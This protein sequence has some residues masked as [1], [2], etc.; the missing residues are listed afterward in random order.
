MRLLSW[1]LQ[2]DRLCSHSTVC[3]Q[4][5][6]SAVHVASPGH[7]ASPV[8]SSS[9]SCTTGCFSSTREHDSQQ[10]SPPSSFPWHTSQVVWGQSASG[11]L[12]PWKQNVNFPQAPEG[13]FPGSSAR[14]T[15]QQ[16]LGRPV[17]R[18]MPVP[19]SSG[20]QAWR[21]EGGSPP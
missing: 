17:T 7:L 8:S 10:H 18:A 12:S 14:V 21:Q 13:T 11:D 19:T 9:K 20:F 16:L 3:P 4:P 15:P 6:A 5:L 1:L 2:H